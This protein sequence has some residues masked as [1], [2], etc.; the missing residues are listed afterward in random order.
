MNLPP[1]LKNKFVAPMILKIF[2][3]AAFYAHLPSDVCKMTCHSDL[4]D[5]KKAFD[6][7]IRRRKREGFALELESSQ[8]DDK[9][10]VVIKTQGHATQLFIVDNTL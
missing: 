9:N 6:D 3:G 7:V 5:L 10:I 4:V 2:L 8:D 1:P